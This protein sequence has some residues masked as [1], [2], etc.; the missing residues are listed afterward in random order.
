MYYSQLKESIKKELES[1]GLSPF[2]VGRRN[3]AKIWKITPY[4][5]R[6][7]L[8]DLR[9]EYSQ[10][11]R[12][13]PQKP[14][15]GQPLKEDSPFE[16]KGEVNGVKMFTGILRDS[17]KPLGIDAVNISKL[18]E[19]YNNFPN[20]K[21]KLSEERI[22]TSDKLSLHLPSTRI[23]TLEDLIA[24]FE[25]DMS[26]W[27]VSRFVCN[28]WEVGAKNKDGEIEVS[29]LYQVKADFKPKDAQQA[30][31]IKKEIED[32]VATS[33][34]RFRSAPLIIKDTALK[35]RTENLVE[36]CIPDLHFNRLV[37]NGETGHGNW[38]SKIA[39]SVFDRA[40]SD[41]FQQISFYKP[42]KIVFVIGNDLLNADNIQAT[43]TRGTPQ[44]NDTRY[45]KAFEDVRNMKIAAIEKFRTL[46]PVEVITLPGNH[47]RLASWHL[48]DSIKML[49]CKTQDVT[50][51]TSALPR[52][53]MKW[54][55]CG[56]CWTHGDEIKRPDLPL[57]FASEQREMW[58]STK[59]NEIHLGHLHQT[60]VQEFHGVRVRIL[61][62]L[63]KVNEWENSKGYTGNIRC[64]QAYVWNKTNG[65]KAILHYN[66]PD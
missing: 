16:V 6:T 53:Y 1:G 48:G 34:A 60:Q 46:C 15:S 64:A 22:Q 37:W 49:Y 50:V 58:G 62:V 18:V 5:A 65:L 31:A 44:V 51:D 29:P 24:F 30:D 2:D 11:H 63:C 43:T 23:H 57:T 26:V 27:E 4:K 45:H 52:K 47:D 14:K 42:E 39:R 25:V 7:I 9:L 3:L 8:E 13:D 19:S 28:K 40:T 35:L 56:L 33:E 38:D 12:G 20:G 61:P 32:L 10:T 17:G 54:G 41:L 36:I 21:Q 66:D 59:Y 55:D